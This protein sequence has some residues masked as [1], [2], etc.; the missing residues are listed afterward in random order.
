[1]INKDSWENIKVNKM[2]MYKS[3]EN[4][5]IFLFKNLDSS[6]GILFELKNNTFE[7]NEITFVEF[8][9]RENLNMIDLT[10]NNI[11][12]KDIFSIVC[13]D[14]ISHI[15]PNEEISIQIKKRLNKWKDLLKNR[16]NKN[17][18]IETQ[19][20]IYSELKF[21]LEILE[22]KFG[23]E[24]AILSWYG[25]EKDKQDFVLKNR[26]IEI[27]SHRTSKGDVAIIS[28][29]NQ[30]YSELELYLVN[31]ALSINNEGESIKELYEQIMKLICNNQ[32]EQIFL[33]KLFSCNYF[34]QDD[35][36]NLYNFSQDSIKYYL[37]DENF[38]KI[39]REGI[40]PKIINLNYMIDLTEVNKISEEQLFS[41]I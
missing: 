38:P 4:F 18:S 24:E 28:S 16:Q 20:G 8:K 13:N 26:A 3:D 1:M 39:N 32:L 15:N 2:S 31:Y 37:V 36:G 41:K 10:L 33:E 25:P 5:N 9:Y 40:S 23:I 6:L 17:L 30:L 12:S 35:K 7:E 21:L 34:P 27:K 29:I 22:P 11:E 14:I 19:M